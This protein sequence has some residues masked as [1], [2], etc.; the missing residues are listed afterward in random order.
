M[1]QMSYISPQSSSRLKRTRWCSSQ[2]PSSSPSQVDT[3]TM[4]LIIEQFLLLILIMGRFM[5][6]RVRISIFILKY[7][8]NIMTNR[9]IYC[10]SCWLQPSDPKHF[11]FQGEMTRDELAQLLLCYIGTAADIIEF[12]DSFKVLWNQEEWL[13]DMSDCFLQDDKVNTNKILCMVVLIIWSGA[14]MQFTITINSSGVFL[15][16]CSTYHD[17]DDFFFI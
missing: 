7:N 12:F 17:E 14:L 4:V 8:V 2:S 16:I 15:Y 1:I 3:D 9:L 6:P 5:M 11:P 13:H 10:Q